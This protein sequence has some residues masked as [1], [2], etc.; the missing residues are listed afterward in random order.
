M[1]LGISAAYKELSDPDRRRSY[2]RFGFKA[3]RNEGI[4][5]KDADDMFNHLFS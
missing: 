4:T 2:D 3:H 1:F 5:F